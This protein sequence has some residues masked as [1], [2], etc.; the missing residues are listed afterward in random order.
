MEK[1][2]KIYEKRR[3][4]LVKGLN[5]IGWTTN[6]P[7]AT[8]YVWTQI[9]KREK[10]CMDFVKKLIDVG[11]VVTPG[12]GFGQY[13]EEFVRFALTQPIERIKESIERI[14]QVINQI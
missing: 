6:K 3:D 7:Q 8:F 11:V 4:V 1:N 10:S 2:V 14:S 9:P 12:I 13:G 5:D